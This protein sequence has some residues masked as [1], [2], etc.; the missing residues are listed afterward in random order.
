MNAFRAGALVGLALLLSGLGVAPAAATGEGQYLVHDLGTAVG[1]RNILPPGAAGVITASDYL[2][3]QADPGWFPP[4]VTDQVAPYDGPTFTPAGAVTPA[5]VQQFSKEE[6]FGVPDGQ[7]DTVENPRPGLTIVRDKAFGVPHIF[8]TTRALAEY[9]AGWV[10]AEDRLF[11]MD[12]LRHAGRGNL[13]SILGSSGYDSDC[14]THYGTGYDQNDARIQRAQ[15]DPQI[16]ADGQQFADGVNGWIA[17]PTGFPMHTPVEYLAFPNNQPVGPNQWTL[18]DIGAVGALI[19]ASLGGGGGNEVANT[20]AFE[21]MV[22]I[23]GVDKARQL[24]DDLH[25]SNDPESPTTIDQSFPYETRAQRD[26]ASVALLDPADNGPHDPGGCSQTRL[27]PAPPGAG[28]PALPVMPPVAGQRTLD[29]PT[30]ARVQQAA[31]EKATRMVQVLQYKKHASNATVVNA[32]HSV[33]GHPIANFGPQVA[34]WMPE[35]FMEMDVH[36]PDWD[37]RGVQIPGTGVFVEIGRGQGFAWSATSAGS[38]NID[39]RADLLCNPAPAAG[40]TPLDNVDPASTSFWYKGSCKKMFENT[41]QYPVPPSA[42]TMGGDIWTGFETF[43]VE[44]TEHD[45]GTG[46]VQGRTRALRNGRYVPVAISV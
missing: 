24:F 36:A 26:P 1:V 35:L 41:I 25:A 14:G 21:R 33:D 6:T 16:V 4:H 37:A 15:L 10:S 31:T 45:D 38:D 3:N 5:Q 18:E 34:Y 44:R 28:R 19:G 32:D 43:R 7:V 23:Y 2:H 11:M 42:G 8:A 30:Q 17:S 27:P 13:A 22:S 20:L 9:G 12:L 46:I 39:E 29:A 40:Q